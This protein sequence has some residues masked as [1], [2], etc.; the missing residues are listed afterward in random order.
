VKRPMGRR[1]RGRPGLVILLTLTW[2][3][4]AHLGAQS[5]SPEQIVR[6]AEQTVFPDAF[7]MRATLETRESGAV[8]SRTEMAVTYKRGVGSRIEL[9][10][11]PRSRGIRFLQ[12]E[13]ALWIF[14]PQAGTSQAIR[15]SPKAAF[16]GSVFSNRD[17]GDPQYST[18]YDMRLLGTENFDHPE[19]GRVSALVVE[20]SA[21]NETVAYSMVKLWVRQSDF[22]LLQGEY[23][24]KS[25]LLFKQELFTGIREMAGKQRPTVIHMVS[26][27]QP[28]RES[29]M[30]MTSLT[31]KPDL[32]DS[33]FSLAALT[34]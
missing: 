6:R 11:P 5:L 2:W 4:C 8:R 29:V 26:L 12:K 23:Y 3:G 22:M 20:G 19:L 31:E 34:R 1:A 10:S 15:L 33:L 17:I 24:A 21:R 16:Q 9:L 7:V 28:G 25:G 30:T 27:D 14:N 32:P 18:Q 13:S